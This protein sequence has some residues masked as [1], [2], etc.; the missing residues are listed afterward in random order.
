MKQLL[1]FFLL[2]VHLGLFGQ[3]WDHIYGNPGT[4]ESFKDVIELYDRGYLISGSYELDEGNW[5]IKTDING[6][7]IWDKVLSWEDVAV[8]KGRLDQDSEGNIGVASLVYGWIPGNWQMITKLNPCGDKLWCKVIQ[9]ENFDYGWFS[10]ILFLDNG[11]ILALAFME[12]Q[13]GFESVFLYY[14]DADGNVLWKKSYANQ[15]DHSLIREAN[16][17]RIHQ[18][19]DNFLLSGE[20]YYPYPWDTTHF[21]QRPLFVMVDSLFNEK[22]IIPFG[23]GDTIHG[24]AL[25]NN[26]LNNSVFIGVGMRRI[27]GDI[28]HSL[29]MYFDDTGTEIGYAEIPNDS[30]G[31]NISQNYI[32]DIERVNDSLFMGLTGFGINNSIGLIGE[33][34]FDTAGKIY[35]QEY[36]PNNTN[37]FC[38]LIKT[39][40]NKFLSATNWVEGKTD[41]DIYAYKINENLEHDTLYSGTYTYDSLC[42]Y[43]IQSGIVDISDCMLITDVGEVPTPEEYYT[44]LQ[45]I[46]IKAYPN[47]ATEGMI[48]LALQNTEQYEVMEL[49]CLNIFG[50]VVQTEQVYPYQG[51]SRIS[52]SEWKSGIYLVVVYAEGRPVGRTKFI[53]N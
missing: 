13:A 29:L 26:Q 39:F 8:F 35:K 2:M 16:C 41:W 33:L 12:S 53:L 20:C 7:T 15:Y 18:Y 40:N 23:V 44:S 32:F 5:L 1:F 38:T 3:K 19:G 14:I 21:Y 51:E 49:R 45:T 28:E 43:Q 42:P 17:D 34:I 48:T 31:S 37:S 47:P 50:Q 6:E 27:G 11:D 10:D 24:K 30:I 25:E 4:D 52:V 22:W 9:D 36:R 46:S